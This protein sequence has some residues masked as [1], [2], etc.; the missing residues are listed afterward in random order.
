M[1]SGL[2]KSELITLAETTVSRGSE[3]DTIANQYLDLILNQIYENYVWEILSADPATI[4]LSA[5]SAT[6]TLPTDFHKFKVM[7]L[8]RTDLN[9][10]VPPNIPL[11]KIEFSDY[12]M[13][14]TPALQGTP[15]IVALNKVYNPKDDSG[16]T[17]YIWPVPN[18]TYTARL[19]YYV[20]PTYAAATNT[21]PI[22]PDQLSLLDLLV[23]ELQ[24]YLGSNKYIPN[25]VALFVKN[26]RL[27]ME[28]QGIY[29][30]IAPLDKRRFR[31]MRS[32]FT[33][34]GWSDSG[35]P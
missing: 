4:T 18:K 24:G 35:N 25:A 17:A 28:D 26:Y 31:T 2:L 8:V 5:G 22:F 19:S 3:L 20:R 29:P 16:V 12:Q 10:T 21:V 6:W 34:F 13:I 30:K 1:S 33:P 11:H 14:R 32:K 15:Q 23:N 9:A 27:N 7:M